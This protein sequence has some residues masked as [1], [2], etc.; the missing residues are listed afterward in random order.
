MKLKKK[1]R[2][3][4]REE[5]KNYKLSLYILSKLKKDLN[6]NVQQVNRQRSGERSRWIQRQEHQ[7]VANIVVI[8]VDKIPRG[9]CAKKKGEETGLRP[10]GTP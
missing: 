8:R 3:L 2:V 5:N 7:H 9:K 1:K 10:W 6:T 4:G